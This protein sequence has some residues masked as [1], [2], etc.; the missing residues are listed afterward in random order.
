MHGREQREGENHRRIVIPRGGCSQHMRSVPLNSTR[1]SIADAD[2]SLVCTTTTITTCSSADYFCK[3]GRKISVGDCALFKPPQDSPPFIG[4]IRCLALGKDNNLKLGVNWLYRPAEVKL[5]KGIPLDAAP[6]ELFYSFHKDEIPAASLLHPCKVAFLPKGAE[7]PTGISSFVCQRVYDIASKCLWWLTDQDYIDERQEEVDKLL[8]RT[9]VEMDATLQPGGRSPKPSSNL[10]SSQLKSGSEGL[11]NSATSI[12][13]QTKGKKRERGDQSSDPVKRERSSKTDDSDSSLVKSENALRSEIAKMT[14]RGGLVDSESVEKL[15]QLIQPDRMDKKMDLVTRSMIAGV[16]AATERFDCL[17]RFVQLKGLPVLDEWLQDVNKGRIGDGG[18]SKDGDKSSE[19]FLLVLLRALDKLPVNL[20]ALQTSNIGRSVNHLRSHKNLEIQRKARSLVDTWKKR[21]EAEMNVIDAKSGSTQ[22]ASWPSKSRLP[23]GHSGRNSGGPG[24]V[25]LKS[26]VTHL[27]ASKA[28]AVKVSHVETT[29]KSASSSPGPM[30]SASSPASAKEVQPRAAAGG[31]TDV[32]VAAREDK[33]SS[34]S[35]SHNYSQSFSGKEDARSSTA[36]SMSVN[37]ISTGGSRHRKSV[38][39][40]PGTS[41]SGSPKE[42]GTGRNSF[43]HRNAAQEKFSQSAATGEKVFDVPV[44]EGSTHKLIVKIPNRGRSPA[45]SM[46]GGSFEDPAIMSSRAS[47][48]VLSDRHEQSDRNIKDKCD[49]YRVNIPSDVNA[50]SWQ[51]ND[52]KDLQVGSEEGDGSPAAVPDEERNKIVEDRKAPEASKMALSTSGNDLK[53]GKLRDASFSSMNAL[54]ESCAKY[55]E[56]NASMSPADDV[57]MNLLASVAAGEMCKSQLVSPTD[58]PQGSTPAVEETCVGD[59]AKSKPP[60]ADNLAQEQCVANDAADGVEEKQAVPSISSWSK[61]GIHLA[62]N[63]PVEAPQDKKAASALSEETRETSGNCSSQVN[64]K[65]DEIKGSN[66]FP[67]T[68]KISM[69]RDGD[70]NK[71]SHEEKGLC[72]TTREDGVPDSKL[73]GDSSSNEVMVTNVVSHT[74][75]VK[76]KAE[77][78]SSNASTESDCKKDVNERFTSTLQLDQK[79]LVAE[80]TTVSCKDLAAEDADELR[81]GEVSVSRGNSCFNQP[82]GQKLGKESSRSLAAEDQSLAVSGSAVTNH[83]NDRIKGGA[84]NFEISETQSSGP[85]PQT[86]SLVIPSRDADGDVDLKRSKLSDAEANR[87]EESKPTLADDKSLSAAGTLEMDSKVNF[88]LNEGLGDDG[89][90]GEPMTLASSGGLSN[91]HLVNISSSSSSI[92]ASITVAAAA[93]G[94]FVPPVDLLRSKGELG[95]RGSAATSAFRPAEPRKV[96]QL[97][98]GPTNASTPDDSSSKPC[99]PP[100]DIDLNVPDERVLEDMGC[101]DSTVDISSNSDLLSNNDRSKNEVS[102]SGPGRSSGGL[103]LDLNRVDDSS[104][105]MQYPISSTRRLEAN[106]VP[107]KSLS[108]SSLPS[109]EVR[110]DF[111]LNGPG[112]DDAIAEQSSFNQQGRSSTLSVHPQ[113]PIAGIRPNS[114]ESGNFTAWFPSGNSYS[115]VAIPSVL[116]DRGEQQPFPIIAP[117]APQRILGPPGGNPFTPDIYRGSVLSSSPA[118]PFA[119]SPFPYQMFPFGTTLP[120]PSATFSVGSTSYMDS[121]SGG[122]LFNPPVN[123]Q[124]LGPVSAVPSQYPRPYMASLADGSNNGGVEN[125]RKWTR[126]GLDLNAGPGALDAEVREETLAQRQLSVASSQALAEEQAR[127]YPVA[128]VVKR[129]EPDGGWDNESF[130][131]KQSSWQ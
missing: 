50:E 69:A 114:L 100:L 87:R 54:I 28:A 125:N 102:G 77:V 61:D 25:A 5:G 1:T 57:G 122:R 106:I 121:Q 30:K 22:A 17:N 36:V 33:S 29:T 93:K 90:Y 53:S 19:E 68:V 86:E 94:P 39:G 2:S 32:P 41:V 91:V 16:I 27:S 49:A 64:E 60:P 101:Q 58:S 127:M 120:L 42:T 98:M 111:D 18:S 118:V 12:P 14:E 79:P 112:V 62:G 129:K 45:Q 83:I 24:D 13:S 116:P 105:M 110:R 15:V 89:K 71:Q 3:D 6:N 56:A 63:P 55:S 4:L 130:R 74:E 96:L 124:F 59:D 131:Y 43:V 126:Q 115:S 10:I 92:P 11:Q 76:Q 109:N 44:V 40:F 97:P 75:D 9:R 72:N 21:V 73:G 66:S 23:E 8:N 78:P 119:S 107:V 81:T 31:G 34:S 67:P 88:D 48:P 37:K 113:L 38:N 80:Q 95:W 51:S 35:Q 99:R 7:L 128:G 65:S 47:S 52:F 108:S 84:Q 20:H 85:F 82:E 104:D 70:Q 46:S 103:D 123:S 26:S 117:G